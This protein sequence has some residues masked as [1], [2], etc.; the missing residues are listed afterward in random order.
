MKKNLIVVLLIFLIP[1]ALYALLGHLSN[2][3]MAS[4]DTKNS[5]PQIVKFTSTMCLD[6]Q[7][8]TKIM[9]ELYPQY[10]D[11]IDLV[12]INVQ[13]GNK[14]NDSWIKKYNVTLV[15]TIILINSSGNEVKRIE[16]AIEKDKMDECLKEL[17]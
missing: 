9:K 8:M 6:C 13:D 12:E 7:T 11:R 10:K 17:K 4:A 1:I 5:R 3:D 14:K 16:G 2:S 15:P